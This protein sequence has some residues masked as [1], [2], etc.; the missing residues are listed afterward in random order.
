[1]E[2][3][4]T[5]L[6]LHEEIKQQQCEIM[7]LNFLCLEVVPLVIVAIVWLTFFSIPENHYVTQSIRTFICGHYQ[8]L[9]LRKNCFNLA[10]ELK[11]SNIILRVLEKG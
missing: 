5:Q 3:I 2:T 11:P 4:L 8:Y 1:M 7:G 10:K 9:P 6:T